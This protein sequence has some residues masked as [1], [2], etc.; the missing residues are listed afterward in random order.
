MLESESA[1]AVPPA[2]PSVPAE[3]VPAPLANGQPRPL[4]NRAAGT[5]SAEPTA[6]PAAAP[7]PKTPADLEPLPTIRARLAWYG[8][9]GGL[10]GLLLAGGVRLDQVTLR[11]P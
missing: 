4:L 10:T 5:P 2:E 6:I 11:A 9:A 7:Q 3:A 8:G 1:P